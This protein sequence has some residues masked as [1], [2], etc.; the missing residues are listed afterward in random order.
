MLLKHAVVI[1]MSCYKFLFRPLFPTYACTSMSASEPS[2]LC[3]LV[4]YQLRGLLGQGSSGTYAADGTEKQLVEI[5][6]SSYGWCESLKAENS[7]HDRS[8]R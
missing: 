8:F 2:R 1:D 5:S 3:G 7:R 4:H 6:S